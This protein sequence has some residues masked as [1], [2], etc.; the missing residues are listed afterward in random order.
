MGE[1]MVTAVPLHT[2]LFTPTYRPSATP[3]PSHTPRPTA[4]A[5]PRA[6]PTPTRFVIAAPSTPAGPPSTYQLKQWTEEDA[7]TA[8]AEAQEFLWNFY[9]S[10]FSGD[11]FEYSV[12]VN[13]ETLLR[14]P[15][16]LHWT[17]IAWEL[18]Q[19]EF[20][21]LVP[22]RVS[23]TLLPPLLEHALNV[24]SVSPRQLD[25]YLQQRG[26]YLYPLQPADNVLP[27]QESGTLL[28]MVSAGW[29][30]PFET[31]VLLLL[32]GDQAGAYQIT[33][34]QAIGGSHPDYELLPVEDRNGNG[35]AEV[36]LVTLE[37]SSGIPSPCGTHLTLLEWHTDEGFTNLVP[38]VQEFVTSSHKSQCKDLWHFEIN[39]DEEIPRLIERR[40]YITG[41]GC[42]KLVH[43][44]TYVW[45]GQEYAW[46]KAEIEPL[47]AESS[48]ICAIQWADEANET[49]DQAVSILEDALTDWP[50]AMD[51][52]WGP[53]SA[54][55]FRLK[56]GIWYDWRGESL[57]ARQ[58]IQSVRDRPAAPEYTLAAEL[59]RDYLARRQSSYALYAACAAANQTYGT[60]LD[61]I[62]F[63]D[64]GRDL[65]VM[66]ETWGFAAPKWWA[67]GPP[68]ICNVHTAFQADAQM[69]LPESRQQAVMDWLNGMGI[70]W[71]AV[72]AADVNQDGLNDW[73]ILTDLSPVAHLWQLWTLVQNETGYTPL[74]TTNLYTDERPSGITYRSSP[75]PSELGTI[76]IVAGS[77]ALTAFTLVPHGDGW[78]V[79][80]L[81]YYGGE[82]A[83][84]DIRLTQTD[85]TFSLYIT[86]N[87]NQHQYDWSTTRATLTYAASHPPT[88]AEQIDHLEQLIFQQSGY[89]EAITQIQTLLTQGIVEPQ[90]W[91]TP[92]PETAHIEPHLRYLLGL[93][94]ELLGDTENAISAYWQVW[95]DFP[96][97][98]YALI[99]RRKL[100]LIAP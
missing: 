81:L 87:N 98:P 2:P 44:I 10:E 73:L 28:L 41:D 53:A 31:G 22:N 59:A 23:N 25:N 54:D 90:T 24:E 14:F 48:A 6:T 26:F 72:S 100:P 88:Q 96:D 99:A 70:P 71:T 75:L 40:Q 85:T 78:R 13:R 35:I 4:T 86:T 55:Y 37:Y 66:L 7:V 58:M 3:R 79:R 30:G 92:D 18:I 89:Q 43:R 84:T 56:L 69:L 12:L 34:I 82:T 60:A 38:D 32:T 21:P 50:T 15:D 77:N 20:H 8:V 11:R 36:G 47:P 1:A 46:Q 61:E 49:N 65:T 67:Y 29:G 97:T 83:V 93:C 95:H 52:L 42:P 5:T 33:M 94:Y 91:N 80:E 68:P 45:D 74:Y 76:N 27:N 62:P 9:T 63:V 17:E 19:I 64:S 57:L 39:P 51:E 16:S